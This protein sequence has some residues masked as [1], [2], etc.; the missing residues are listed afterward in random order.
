MT[1]RFTNRAGQA[2]RNVLSFAAPALVLG[3]VLVS[4]AQARINYPPAPAGSLERAV[5]NILIKERADILL[6]SRLVTQQNA[7]NARI[8]VLQQQ[9][10]QATDPAVIA[11]LQ[12]QIAQQTALFR[13]LQVSID[14][15]KLVLQN[16]LSV[17]N[18]QKDRALA[19]LST[20]PRPRNQIVQFIQAARLQQ[21]TYA[22]V[23]RAFL[24]RR[25]ISPVVSF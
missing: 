17:L 15:N 24:G 18:P 7:T 9:L 12:R 3:L 1:T 14:R 22:A 2:A 19:T 20:L 6:Q 13:S 10:A 11:A 16:N 23:M 5:D 8:G 25:P 21:A 4:Q